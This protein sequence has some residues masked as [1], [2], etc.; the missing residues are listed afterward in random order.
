MTEEGRIPGTIEYE[1]AER[2]VGAIIGSMFLMLALLA[3]GFVPIIVGLQS[4][5][6]DPGGGYLIL[7]AITGLGHIVLG[8]MMFLE[9]LFVVGTGRGRTLGRLARANWPV[10]LGT[11]ADFLLGLFGV[12]F[13]TAYMFVYAQ[14]IA[15]LPRMPNYAKGYTTD[16][17]LGI[18]IVW[19]S[20]LV[21]CFFWALWLDAIL[22]RDPVPRRAM[23]DDELDEE[24]E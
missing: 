3:L 8:L 16:G 9:V 11:T 10:Q 1:V 23:A 4:E 20:V 13:G 5:R 17:W 18:W 19:I 2:S 14:G 6:L 21:G 7:G 22:G 15:D 24:L 12:G